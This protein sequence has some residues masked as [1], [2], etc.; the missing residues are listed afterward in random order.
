MRAFCAPCG[1]KGWQKCVAF[2]LCGQP[3]WKSNQYFLKKIQKSIDKQKP[4]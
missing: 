3:V 2:L 4:L 1:R